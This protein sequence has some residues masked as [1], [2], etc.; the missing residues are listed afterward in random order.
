VVNE[1]LVCVSL[2]NAQERFHVEDTVR[3]EDLLKP[4]QLDLKSRLSYRR[5]SS[6]TKTE[7]STDLR[8]LQVLRATLLTNNEALTEN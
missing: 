4:R 2:C 8:E 3:L 7:R 1:I 5:I 6:E